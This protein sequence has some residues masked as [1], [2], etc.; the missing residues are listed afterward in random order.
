[1]GN[2]GA[3][4]MVL[5]FM[6]VMVGSVF[7][8][9]SMQKPPP[10]PMKITVNCKNENTVDKR[11]VGILINKDTKSM[12]VSGEIVKPEHIRIFNET[13]IEAAWMVKNIKTN[14]F[15]DRIAGRLV[16]ESSRAGAQLKEDHFSCTASNIKF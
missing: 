2:N 7:F 14:I 16:I 8:A 6:L 11:V 9:F 1:M 3:V 12:I 4:L 15:L 13:A 10:E 5:F